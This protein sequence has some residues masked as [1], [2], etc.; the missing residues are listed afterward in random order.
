LL[1]AIVDGRQRLAEARLDGVAQQVAR[2]QEGQQRTQAGREAHQQQAP[3]QAE[4]RAGSQ[5][6]DQRAP[7]I[8]SAAAAT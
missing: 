3:A 8:D 4:H 6:Q 1:H 2:R 7:G 5:R